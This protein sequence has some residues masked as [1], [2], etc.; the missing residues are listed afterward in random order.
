MP[1]RLRH[2]AHAPQ[3]R[4]LQRLPLECRCKGLGLHGPL[5]HGHGPKQL[6]HLVHD[7]LVLGARKPV[8]LK[9]GGRGQAGRGEPRGGP[10]ELPQSLGQLA[11]NGSPQRVLCRVDAVD[12]GV[13]GGDNVRQEDAGVGEGGVKRL[14]VGQ[15]GA[16]CA[17]GGA[18]VLDKAREGGGGCLGAL[19]AVHCLVQGAHGRLE[20]LQSVGL[21]GA[22]VQALQL[23]DEDGRVVGEGRS[24]CDRRDVGLAL[25][26]MELLLG[27]GLDAVEGAGLGVMQRLSVCL[28]AV[29]LVVD[30][31]HFA[32]GARRST[33][34]AMI[35]LV[36]QHAVHHHAAEYSWYAA[37][38]LHTLPKTQF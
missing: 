18:D 8:K 37:I 2:G 10:P 19:D 27:G 31:C 9:G 3:R 32:T 7:R 23:G 35:N 5:Q 33:M 26:R 24:R 36:V 16:V 17:H 14:H 29:H 11:G 1:Q 13:A 21:G 6:L 4:P 12:E 28:Q 15:C 22:H 38:M 25:Q 20:R 34:R 30:A